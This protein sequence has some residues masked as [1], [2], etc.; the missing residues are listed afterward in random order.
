M[1]APGCWRATPSSPRST[2]ATAPARARRSRSRST[3][4]RSPCWSTSRRTCSSP[5][6]GGGRFGNGHPSIVPYTTYRAADAMMAL[7]VGNDSQ[8]ARIAAVLGHPEWADDPRFKRQSRPRREPRR[9][10]RLDRRG[11]RRRQRRRLA[12][13]AQGGRRAVRPINSVAEALDDPHTAARGMIETV[14]HPT[15]GELEDA[16][17][18]L[19]VL[20]HAGLGAPRRRRRSAQH[21]DEILKPSLGSTTTPS[22][23]CAGTTRSSP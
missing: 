16:R 19:Q 15:I 13:E 10:R 11:A 6:K 12:R 17:H 20:R 8:F 2:R 23:S 5:G 22:R 4:R 1:S 3:R 21:T 18:S 14:E 7:A 9:D